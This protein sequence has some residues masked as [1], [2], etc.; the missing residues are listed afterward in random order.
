MTNVKIQMKKKARVLYGLLNLLKD[1]VE[2][3]NSDANHFDLICLEESVRD[4][5]DTLRMLG[6]NVKEIEYLLYLSR[7]SNSRESQSPL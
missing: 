7:Q 3:L 1:D 4:A 6:D 2:Q 5:T